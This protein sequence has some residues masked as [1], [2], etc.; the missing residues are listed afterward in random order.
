MKWKLV[1][2]VTVLAV[3]G[4]GCTTPSSWTTNSSLLSA[5]PQRSLRRPD[6]DS[7][8]SGALVHST[9]RPVRE[10]QD[11]VAESSDFRS[12]GRTQRSVENR[13]ERRRADSAGES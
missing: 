10:G 9:A 5:R 11:Q 6:D 8:S 12:Q 1:T 13:I 3:S 4:Q 7:S 2:L